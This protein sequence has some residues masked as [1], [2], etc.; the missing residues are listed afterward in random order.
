M[1]V[2]H[3][4]SAR[5]FLGELPPAKS[6]IAFKRN[7]QSYHVFQQILETCFPQVSQTTVGRWLRK[8]VT[9]AIRTNSLERPHLNAVQISDFSR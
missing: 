5:I 6:L 4:N 3:C 8:I 9:S 7:D 2:L 1:D